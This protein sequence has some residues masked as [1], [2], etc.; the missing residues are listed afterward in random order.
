LQN[1]DRYDA[2]ILEQ[3]IAEKKPAKK[4][5]PSTAANTIRR[6]ASPV[7]FVANAEICFHASKKI[8]FLFKLLSST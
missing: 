7:S 4:K 2:A 8:S 1:R 6:S 5:F 3:E